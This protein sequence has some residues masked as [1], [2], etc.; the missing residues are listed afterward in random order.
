MESI[1][2]YKENRAWIEINKYNLQKNIEAFQQVLPN[3]CK[4][5]AAVKADAYGHGAIMIAQS[6][7]QCN[8]TNFCV[9]SVQE[10]I[11]LRQAGIKGDILILSYTP[12][13]QL[14]EIS[15]Y[16]FIQTVVDIDYAYVLKEYKKEIRVH[17][18]IDT[19]MHRLG[20]RA[21][22]I[23]E[24]IKLWNIKNLHIEG[25][26]SHLCVADSLKIEDIAYTKEQIQKFNQ[27][28]DSLKKAGKPD[29]GTHLQSSYGVLNYPECQYDYVRLGISLYGVLSENGDKTKINLALTP[30]LSL[31]SRI[32]C[33]K[34]LKEGEKAGYGLEFEAK[35]DGKIAVISI[36][37]ADGIPRN[38]SPQSYVLCHGKKAF[39]VGRICMDQMLIDVTNIADAKPNDEVVIIGTQEEECITA[40]MVANWS[41]TI[42]NEILS[43]LGK[44]LE[45]RM[46]KS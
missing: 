41:G 20:E 14:E 18:G 19:G 27:V 24:I 10:G 29:F 21:E 1:K 11:E 35:E 34:Q 6:L 8:I 44:R 45:R 3:H 28:I 16:D 7:Q 36:G 17:L 40:Q 42:S 31:K 30:V 2:R 13:E 25:I 43:R 4:I 23:D 39:V 32:S 9:A 22:H 46:Q 15:C 37:Y 26:F 5:M 33:I 38:L 12:P